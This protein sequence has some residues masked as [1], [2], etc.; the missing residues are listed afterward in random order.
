MPAEGVTASL[1]LTARGIPA[2]GCAPPALAGVVAYTAQ[3]ADLVGELIGAGPF[4]AVELALSDGSC[5]VARARNGDLLAARGELTVAANA[6]L[7]GLL[8]ADAR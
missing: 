6:L 4:G 5:V 3:L 8:A 1:R 2:G 7:A